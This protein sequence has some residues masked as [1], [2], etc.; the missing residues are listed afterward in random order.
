MSH[1]FRNLILAGSQCIHTNYIY[2]SLYSCIPIQKYSCWFSSL[3]LCPLLWDGL[4]STCYCITVLQARQV[5]ADRSRNFDDIYFPSMDE[6][7]NTRFDVQQSPGRIKIP[8]VLLAERAQ[9]SHSMSNWDE[10]CMRG[11]LVILSV[12]IQPFQ[13][14]I[15]CSETWSCSFQ[16]H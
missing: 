1:I 8:G 14:L 3:F 6:L 16:T 15:S 2:T 9:Q 5:A 7:D 10:S 4:C 12:N 11:Y 13:S